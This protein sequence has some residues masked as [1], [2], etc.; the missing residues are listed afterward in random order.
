MSP[1]KS[2]T[3]VKEVQKTDNKQVSGNKPLPRY[4]D[5]INLD[6]VSPDENNFQVL[7]NQNPPK[8]WI[9][10]LNVGFGKTINYLPIDKIEY[11]LTRLFIDWYVEVIDHKQIAN[12]ITCQVRLY[13]T[14]PVTGKLKHQDGVGAAPLQTDKD[15]GAIDWNKIK[16]NAVQIGLPAAETYAIKDAAEKIGRLFGK[17]LNRKDLMNYES[18]NGRMDNISTDA[19]LAIST[20]LKDLHDGEELNR[21]Y[22]QL[23]SS[24]QKMTG[25]VDKLFKQRAA[26]LNII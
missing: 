3:E 10:Q 24:G 16:T 19:M 6:Y 21:Y 7:L 8:E 5:L 13:Y 15:A 2:T 22:K 9:E 14:S 11:L 17:D 4:E 1:T 26:E 20:S 12:S 18:L 25:V 23:Q